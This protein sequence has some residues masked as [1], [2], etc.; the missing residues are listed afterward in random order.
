MP[1]NPKSTLGT[2]AN[3]SMKNP[4]GWEIH[5]GIRS[6]SA[7]A[8]PIEMGTAMMHRDERGLERANDERAGPVGGPDGYRHPVDV[9]H[10]GGVRLAQV[11]L[12]PGQEPPAVDHDRRTGLDHQDGDG[13][14]Q[15]GERE[16]DRDPGRPLPQGTL[17]R[18]KPSTMRRALRARRIVDVIILGKE[19]C[20]PADRGHYWIFAICFSEAFTIEAGSGW[21]LT[22]LRY[23]GEFPS[24]GV[25]DP[26][27]NR[28]DVLRG[29]TSSSAAS[30]RWR[31]RS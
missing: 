30:S 5:R 9:V 8:A 12:G 17:L 24:F 15:R 11:E 31:T 16:D 6:V 2:P 28:A 25:D 10:R 29:A 14:H 4:R 1:H 21:K 23:D 22:W 26:L 7:K 13:E 18:R 19:T 3:N 20:R 27:E